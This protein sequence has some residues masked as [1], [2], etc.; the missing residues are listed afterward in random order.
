MG[1]VTFSLPAG[2]AKA[3]VGPPRPRCAMPSPG[4]GKDPRDEGDHVTDAPMP[5]HNNDPRL[6]TIWEL[7]CYGHSDALKARVL[8]GPEFTHP[9]LP[10][11]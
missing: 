4:P 10:H 6:M 1:C 9:L 5:P 8:V 11:P 2:R 7:A 3:W